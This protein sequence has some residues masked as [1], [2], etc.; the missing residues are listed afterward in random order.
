[1]T[2]AA[3]LAFQI[4]RTMA[5]DPSAA[6]SVDMGTWHLLISGCQASVGSA[7]YGIDI[8]WPEGD[9]SAAQFSCLQQMGFQFL[10]QEAYTES[11][12]FWQPAVSNAKNA[13]AAG[14]SQIEYYHFFNQ[15]QDPSTQIATTIKGLQANNLTVARLWV[16]I[17]GSWPG[18]P[19]FNQQ[20]L[21][22]A[23]SAIRS[24]GVLPGIY[25]GREWPQI[26]GA[27]FTAFSDVPLWTALFDN[28]PSQRFY[29]DNPWGG[30][31]APTIKQ[32][33]ADGSSSQLA[34]SHCNVTIDWDFL[35]Y[36]EQAHFPV[37]SIYPIKT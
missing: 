36:S 19:Q 11:R 33:S 37:K 25:C 27:N 16:D 14:F 13:M 29:W 3:T 26:F 28:I 15:S 22:A 7:A 21:S 4:N 9:V 35:P 23:I 17:E 18:S 12:G 32:F 1:M 8:G 34:P 30:W 2:Q 10:I 20:F 6:P 31:Q 5:V 24:F